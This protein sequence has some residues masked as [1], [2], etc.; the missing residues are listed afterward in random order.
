MSIF[1]LNSKRHSSLK[2]ILTRTG[3]ADRPSLHT[4]VIAMVTVSIPK[5]RLTNKKRK[6]SNLS[7]QDLLPRAVKVLRTLVQQLNVFTRRFLICRILG[8]RSQQYSYRHERWYKKNLWLEPLGEC[9]SSQILFWLQRHLHHDYFAE[10]QVLSIDTSAE[11]LTFIFPCDI[12]SIVIFF[13]PILIL[14]ISQQSML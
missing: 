2:N 13:S 5:K 6:K 14:L 11:E 9:S 7:K 12:H 10:A 3:E 8:A 4:E 1:F